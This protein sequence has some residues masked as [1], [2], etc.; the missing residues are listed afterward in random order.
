MTTSEH[1][2]Q[3][4]RRETRLAPFGMRWA[5][6]G[7]SSLGGCNGLHLARGDRRGTLCGL[8]GPHTPK[9]YVG[10]TICGSCA[11]IAKVEK[12]VA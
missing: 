8:I 3:S 4:V 10:S 2:P 5:T 12:V 11:R 1:K 7:G 6:G 9:A